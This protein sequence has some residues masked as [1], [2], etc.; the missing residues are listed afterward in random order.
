MS[1]SGVATSKLRC[2]RVLHAPRGR[3]NIDHT[4][5][6]FPP[7]SSTDPEKMPGHQNPVTRL[8]PWPHRVV[9]SSGPCNPIGDGRL[10]FQLNIP[11]PL[12]WTIDKSRLILSLPCL[13]VPSHKP[14]ERSLWP[15][16][17]IHWPSLWTAVCAADRRPA[18]PVPS[19]S[20]I[21]NTKP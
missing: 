9:P 6:H 15:S 4:P 12:A 2:S 17:R 20:W 3:T 10:P 19:T 18:D 14:M 7:I 1:C 16:S 5:T 8:S 13:S 21:A 11:R